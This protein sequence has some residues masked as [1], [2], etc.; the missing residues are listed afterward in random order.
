MAD[1]GLQ[2]TAATPL[3]PGLDEGSRFP[4]LQPRLIVAAALLSSS[5]FGV[6]VADGR[7]KYG[8]AII[9][10]ACYGPL[11]FV[12]LASALAVWVAV[13]FFSG[14]SALSHAPNTMGVLLVLGWLGTFL[15]RRDPRVFLNQ[16]RRL[17][18]TLVMFGIWLTL[19]IAWSSQPSA[20]LSENGYWWLGGLAF[21]IVLTTIDRPRDVRFVALAFLVGSVISVIIGVASG[22]LSSSAAISQT[23]I[24]GRLT[25]GGT[26]P[27]EQAAGFI[28]AMF[29]S[30]GL[31]SVYR[32]RAARACLLLAFLLVTAGFFAT[33]SRGGLIALMVATLASLTLAPEQRRRLARLGAV[34]GV[35]GAVLL[36]AQ[37]G[38]LQRI[39]DLGGGTSGRS[40]L[41]RVA[42][43]V[44]EGHP[45]F[46][47]GSGNFR[48]VETQS[49]YVLRPGNIS[50]IQYLAEVP[51]VAH[52]TY[53]QLLAETGVVGL[54]AFLAVVLAALRSFMLARRRFEDIGR[55]DYADLTTAALM[56]T[57]G[58]LTAVFFITD[59]WDERLWV[60]LA[61]G[62]VLLGIATRMRSPTPEARV[63]AAE[64]ALG[65]SP[66]P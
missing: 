59:G 39:T 38:T 15:G 48:V 8:L 54:F 46:G 49:H 18:L 26:D 45:L 34:V 42:W 65:R 20:T 28:A 21:L 22:A 6:V 56:G 16:H 52:N 23:A 37:P 9:L 61:L 25:G 7:I 3:G 62:P 14:L 63:P 51:Q 36:A 53:L 43:Q 24:N 58:F 2:A 29:L 35:A 41:W 11:V 47:V 17:L 44:F 33:Q 12:D 60:L 19:T 32:R 66:L 57:I 31:L 64:T 4:Y 5:L 50:R 30:A 1:T 27:N 40:D 55:S 10:A 13:L